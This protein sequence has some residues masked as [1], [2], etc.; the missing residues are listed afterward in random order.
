MN[1]WNRLKCLLGNH[2]YRANRAKDLQP[3]ACNRMYFDDRPDEKIDGCTLVDK[4]EH[5]G[6]EKELKSPVSIVKRNDI[7]AEWEENEQ[8]AE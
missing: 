6:K 2:S 5:C 8:D 4:C 7:P 1:I 3:N